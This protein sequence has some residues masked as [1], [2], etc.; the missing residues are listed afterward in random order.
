MDDDHGRMMKRIGNFSLAVSAAL[1]ATA[2]SRVATLSLEGE[3]QVLA[4][5]VRVSS[6]AP[7]GPSHIPN[8]TNLS[9][10]H[11]FVDTYSVS[12]TYSISYADGYT[13]YNDYSNQS[14]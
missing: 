5:R 12:D 2:S 13:V 9:M 4:G 11:R 1:V 14:Q 6:A 7:A 3:V 10:N 8:L